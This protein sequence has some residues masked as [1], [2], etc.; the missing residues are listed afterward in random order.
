MAIRS[1][2]VPPLGDG[3]CF[4]PQGTRIATSGFALLAMSWWFWAGSSGLGGWL[5][6]RGRAI[7]ES[8]LRKIT[9]NSPAGDPAGLLLLG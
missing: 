8:P 1:L 3:R 7:L 4:A 2:P 5:L 9:K 6:V